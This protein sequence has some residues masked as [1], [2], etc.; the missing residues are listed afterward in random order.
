MNDLI[1]IPGKIW[2][3]DIDIVLDSGSRRSIIGEDLA[4]ELNL[5]PAECNVCLRVVNDSIVKPIGV[6]QVPVTFKSTTYLVDALVVSKFPY[7]LLCGLDFLDMCNAELNFRTKSVKIGSDTYKINETF[8]QTTDKVYVCQDSVIPA[9]SE[10]MVPVMSG[11][12]FGIRVLEPAPHVL[13]QF[14]T[15]VCGTLV[16][17]KNN[18]SAVRMLNPTNHKILIP[19]STTIANAFNVFEIHA[20]E[21][22]ETSNDNSELPQLNIGN[23]LLKHEK[24]N[25]LKVLRK[26][27]SVFSKSDGDIG[28]TSLIKHKIDTGNA[29][30]IRMQPY[31]KSMAE[32]EVINEEVQKLLDNGIIRESNSPWGAPVVL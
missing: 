9:F 13:Q 3:T 23:G 29:R 30:P 1:S 4:K 24:R 15:L 17:F 21:D 11:T 12:D 2:N 26:F 25:L 27:K 14:G 7:K 8:F 19:R 18:C 31:R 32:R 20:M 5:T 16:E 22:K 6:V 28:H 10:A